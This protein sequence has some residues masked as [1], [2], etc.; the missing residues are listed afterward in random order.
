[1]SGN[2]TGLEVIKRHVAVLRTNLCVCLCVCVCVFVWERHRE[3]EAAVEVGE[4]RHVSAFV[5]S[6]WD[7]G[8][9]FSCL[10]T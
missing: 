5:K 4:G 6:C 1:M 7:S 9:D 3:R 8:I 10:M 2:I